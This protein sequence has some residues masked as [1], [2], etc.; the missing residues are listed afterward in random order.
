MTAAKRV[1]TRNQP[2]ASWLDLGRRVG[3]AV[4]IS[5]LLAG[6]AC[7]PDGGDEA[8]ADGAV[9]E[10]TRPAQQAEVSIRSRESC[11]VV[12]GVLHGIPGLVVTARDTVVVD[13]RFR[14]EAWGCALSVVGSVAEFRDSDYPDQVLRLKL[15][16]REWVEDFGYGADG[17]DGTATAFRNGPV[18]CFLRGSWDGGDITDSTYVPEDWYLLNV[19]CV[20]SA[21]LDSPS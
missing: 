18:I 13:P 10:T 6:A 19:G 14:G 15:T 11:E 9:L 5:L 7:G 20:E 3:V 21:D 2:I 8:A 1:N 16:A 12:T 4:S 17:P